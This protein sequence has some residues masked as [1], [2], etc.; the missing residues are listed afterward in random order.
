MVL[1][2]VR[3]WTK[4]DRDRAYVDAV[5]DTGQRSDLGWV[6]LVT[7]AIHPAAPHITPDQ[8]WSPVAA[9]APTAGVRLPTAPT[10]LNDHKAG[11]SLKAEASKRSGGILARL[12]GRDS[13]ARA[14]RTGAKGEKTA[15]KLLDRLGSDW[16]VLHSVQVGY[17][18]ADIDHVLIGPGGAYTVNTK[19]HPDAKITVNAHGI[20]VNGSRTDYIT[21]ARREADI[22]HQVLTRIADTHINVTPV[23]LIIDADTVH[24]R[25]SPGVTVL[26][27]TNAKPWFLGRG[28]AFTPT[29]V[30]WL[31]DRAANPDLWLHRPRQP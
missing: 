4:G 18:G 15:G 24:V 25:A 29:Q 21:K 30:T 22:A 19:T 1:P 28:T 2:R 11:A 20:W 3:R 14:W 27:P 6:D 12:T 10:T 8:V 13:D 26:T 23:L 9:W 7:G 5:N 31:A 17:G 16:R